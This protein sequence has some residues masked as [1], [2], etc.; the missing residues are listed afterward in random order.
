MLLGLKLIVKPYFHYGVKIVQCTVEM[1]AR[2][3]LSAKVLTYF[4]LC[5]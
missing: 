2:P 1:P 4:A 5:V 3:T